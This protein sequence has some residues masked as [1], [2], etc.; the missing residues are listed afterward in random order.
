MWQ[1]KLR[2]RSLA[3][4]PSGGAGGGKDATTRE[5]GA[6]GGK[7]AVGR[8]RRG[9]GGAEASRARA[10]KRR[11]S[12]WCSSAARF[13]GMSFFYEGVAGRRHRSQMRLS[14]LTK[15]TF[16]PDIWPD[17]RH[18]SPKFPAESPNSSRAD[19]SCSSQKT[20]MTAC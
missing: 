10:G 2:R 15:H 12:P 9:P 6:G 17:P 7:D 11:S 1:H 14:I 20:F 16:F 3:R 4:R 18:E 13:V 5:E 19:S 8:A